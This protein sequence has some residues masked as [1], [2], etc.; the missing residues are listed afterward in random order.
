MHECVSWTFYSSEFAS[1]SLAKLIN[2]QEEVKEEEIV[3]KEEEEQEEDEEEYLFYALHDVIMEYLKS[4][5]TQEEQKHYHLQLVQKYSDKCG[6]TFS[7][8]E[9]DGYIHQQ[10]LVHVHAA[11]NMELLGQLLTNLLWMAACCKHW[12]ASS[13]MDAYTRYRSCLPKVVRC[14]LSRLFTMHGIIWLSGP[15]NN[16]DWLLKYNNNDIYTV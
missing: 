4:S 9:E 16:N 7:E 5:I 13:L 1:H 8:L 10:L 12:Y 14:N 6:G 2:Q 15:C 3:E 11:G